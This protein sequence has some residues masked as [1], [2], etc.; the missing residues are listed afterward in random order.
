M[1]VCLCVRLHVVKR[2]QLFLSPHTSTEKSDALPN[3]FK[4]WHAAPSDR[5]ARG[6]TLPASR[7]PPICS[8]QPTNRGLFTHLTIALVPAISNSRGRGHEA[9][10]PTFPS[11]ALRSL[12]QHLE[13]PVT[14]KISILIHRSVIYFPKIKLTPE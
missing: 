9:K 13:K 11:A 3:G 10:L 12:S 2:A 5:G 14:S 1:F 6:K 8:N 7:S 4:S